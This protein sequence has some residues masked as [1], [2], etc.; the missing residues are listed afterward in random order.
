MIMGSILSKDPSYYEGIVME[1]ADR[2]VQTPTR[3]AKRLRIRTPA[4]KALRTFQRRE[5]RK[6]RARE[7]REKRKGKLK[8]GSENPN[9]IMNCVTCRES[10]SRNRNYPPDLQIGLHYVRRGIR[11]G[12]NSHYTRL[13]LRGILRGLP[14]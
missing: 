5:A 7:E 6:L 14:G 1:T 2:T 12:D 9:L 3:R 8:H 13:P 4:E 11:E 10:F